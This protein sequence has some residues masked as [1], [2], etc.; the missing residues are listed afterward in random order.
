MKARQPL[1]IRTYKA[2]G[3]LPFPCTIIEAARA[4]TAAPTFFKRAVITI[5]GIEQTYM[6]GGLAQNNPSDV[7]LQEADLVFPGRRM[8]CIVSIGT[9]QLP[10]NEITEPNFIKRLIPIDVAKAL[11]NIATDTEEK[12]ED[13]QR[14][15]RQRQEIYHRFNVDQGLQNV[16]LD[17]WNKLGAVKSHTQVYLGSEAVKSKL[18]EAVKV[19]VDQRPALGVGQA[20]EV[21]S[22]C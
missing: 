16:T 22:L 6:D 17:E 12:H 19:L 2:P 1:L 5:D 21:T 3:Q 7:V 13:L 4:T 9:G 15:F 14:R 18:K 11:A 20:S 10:I 8:A